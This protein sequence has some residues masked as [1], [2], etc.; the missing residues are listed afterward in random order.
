MLDL[1]I[2]LPI[3]G[4]KWVEAWASEAIG[5]GKNSYMLHHNTLR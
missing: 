1:L 3:Y 2:G 5:L 4:I